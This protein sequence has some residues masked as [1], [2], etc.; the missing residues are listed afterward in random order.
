MNPFPPPAPSPSLQ[1]VLPQ[2]Q[3]R[4][5]A[6]AE[7]HTHLERMPPASCIPK[8]FLSVRIMVI[9]NPKRPAAASRRL[10]FILLTLCRTPPCSFLLSIYLYI[11]LSIPQPPISPI[12]PPAPSIY[13]PINPSVTC[14]SEQLLKTFPRGPYTTARTHTGNHIFEFEFHNRRISESTRLMV[15]AESLKKPARSPPP[16]TQPTPTSMAPPPLLC[17]SNNAY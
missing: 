11:Y 7:S 9:H 17:A 10:F 3:A 13:L 4:A 12:L 16:P 5:K 1:Q 14:Q 6:R 8:T 15:D 2:R